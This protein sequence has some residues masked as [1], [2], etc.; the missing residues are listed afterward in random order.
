MK[1]IDK[2][3]E[4]SILDK[5][6][7]M[8]ICNYH[9]IFNDITEKNIEKYYKYIC[10]VISEADQI[11][12]TY[13]PK[14][15]LER[16]YF[17]K[18]TLQSSLIDSNYIYSI[19]SKE[20]KAK[21]FKMIKFYINYPDEDIHI[22]LNYNKSY[23]AHNE[24]LNDKEI[25][26][27]KNGICYASFYQ[28]NGVIGDYRSEEEIKAQKSE[29]SN[30]WYLP[31]IKKVGIASD[32]EKFYR[33]SILFEDIYDE[34]FNKEMSLLADNYYERDNGKLEMYLDIFRDYLFEIIDECDSFSTYDFCVREFLYYRKYLKYEN[35]DK[36]T[37]NNTNLLTSRLFDIKDLEAKNKFKNLFIFNLADKYDDYT[38]LKVNREYFENQDPHDLGNLFFYKD[39]KLVFIIDTSTG[40][41][42][43]YRKE[44]IIEEQVERYRKLTNKK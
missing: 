30:L 22:N 10:D 21:I 5:I 39:N 23:L 24:D 6:N 32:N 8:T 3:K 7:N 42:R 18:I 12:F 40:N 38:E 9:E 26:M 16:E 2:T 29:L 4:I 41:V 27:M 25:I 35:Y 33:F 31:K 34:Y 17:D 36:I 37:C 19:N 43:D 1:E 13:D 15:D 14:L 11:V 28:D 20:D 44:E